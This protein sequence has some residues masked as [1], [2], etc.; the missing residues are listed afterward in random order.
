M[1][2]LKYKLPMALRCAYWEMHRATDGVL[3]GMGATANQFVI[4]SL[5]YEHGPLIQQEIVRRAS[6]D[7]NTIRS[8]LVVLERNGLIAREVSEQDR[9][10]W[11]ISLTPGG[12]RAFKK[13][14]QATGNFRDQLADSMEPS[15]LQTL[16]GLLEKL[17]KVAS[18]LK[19][20]PKLAKSAAAK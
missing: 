2:E 13:M 3:V 14:W 7:P 10:A 9:R 5:I 8:M 16:V 6:S 1:T 17:A 4:L 15:E 19:Q 11:I 20:N 18:A 12:R